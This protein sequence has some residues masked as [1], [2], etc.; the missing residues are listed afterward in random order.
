MGVSDFGAYMKRAKRMEKLELVLER[1]KELFAAAQHGQP[2][3][4]VWLAMA[5]LREAVAE[6]DRT[7]PPHHSTKD[8]T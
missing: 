6:A 2:T 8:P 1:A 4:R 3:E 5:K 7:P